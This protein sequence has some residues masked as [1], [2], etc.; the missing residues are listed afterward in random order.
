MS[1]TNVGL[2]ECT[3]SKAKLADSFQKY[4]PADLVRSLH[5]AGRS[6]R[7]HGAS[8]ALVVFGVDHLTRAAKLLDEL[9]TE[10]A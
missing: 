1:M 5:G 8:R 2:K 6:T 4:V 3:S 10:D 7:R 9:A